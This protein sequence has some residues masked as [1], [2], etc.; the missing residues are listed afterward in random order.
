VAL[1]LHR[2]LAIVSAVL[3]AVAAAESAWHLRDRSA[4]RPAVSRTQ[5]VALLAVVVTA[6]GGLGLLLGGARPRELLHFVYAV[7]AVGAIPLVNAMSSEWEPGRRLIATLV[8]GLVALA[9]I[10]RLFATG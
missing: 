3:V 1:E 10:L 8:G 5:T 6:A 4:D 9:V 2:W 7:L